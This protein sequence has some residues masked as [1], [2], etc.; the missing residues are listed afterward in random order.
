VHRTR[1]SRAGDAF[2]RS[3]RTNLGKGLNKTSQFFLWL[4][5]G[6][7]MGAKIWSSLHYASDSG[8]GVISFI[9]IGAFCGGLLAL[10]PFSR[11]ISHHETQNRTRSSFQ[12]CL[13]R[14][15]AIILLVVIW[16]KQ[17]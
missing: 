4:L 8:T 9:A 1:Y 6:A 10:T 15:I 17:S 7:F 11:L 14:L 13:W 12:L 5:A 16:Q 3:G 2:V